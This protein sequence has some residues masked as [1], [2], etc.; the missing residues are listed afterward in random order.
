LA[1][2]VMLPVT[3]PVISFV[4][5]VGC[6]V[7]AIT[8]GGFRL[9]VIDLPTLDRVQRSWIAVLAIILIPLAVWMTYAGRADEPGPVPGTTAPPTTAP[10]LTTTPLPTTTLPP[11]TTTPSKVLVIKYIDNTGYIDIDRQKTWAGDVDEPSGEVDVS[12]NPRRVAS[13]GVARIALSESGGKDTCQ[14]AIEREAPAEI[15]MG[16][17]QDDKG[18]CAQSRGGRIAYIRFM[19]LVPQDGDHFFQFGLTVYK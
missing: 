15:S 3:L 13:E 10:P 12:V 11:S 17:V 16:Q 14:A 7:A 9:I 6:A 1:D 18:F 5:G 4:V 2:S 8:G 19:N